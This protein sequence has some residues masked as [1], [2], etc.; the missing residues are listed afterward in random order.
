MIEVRKARIDDHA[1]IY[2]LGQETLGYDLDEAFS[3]TRLL[4][5]LS[6]PANQIFVAFV[7]NPPA[8]KEAKQSPIGQ[9]EAPSLP[10]GALCY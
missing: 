9:Y 4:D 5:V 3:Q 10:L 1:M 7:Q 8:K 6:K 2:R